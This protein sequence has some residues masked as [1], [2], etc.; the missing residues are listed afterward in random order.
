MAIT[1][2]A[3]AVLGASPDA[4]FQTL[5][6]VDRLPAWNDAI[7]KVV[8]PLAALE[9]GAEWVV[10]VRAL[11]QSW[12]SRSRITAVDAAQRRFGYR[13]CTDDGNPSYALWTWTID[14]H[15]DGGHVTVTMELH[16]ITFWRRVLLARIRARQ[17]GRTELPSSLRALEAAARAGSDVRSDQTKSE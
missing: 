8:E 15:P 6:D 1:K 12:N 16:P 7:V 17:V 9:S 2:T 13:S 11:G 14:P 10:E 5:T 3:E 4:V